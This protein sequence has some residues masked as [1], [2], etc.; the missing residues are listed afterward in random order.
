MT[1]AIVAPIG[2]ISM[3][4]TR[5]YQPPWYSG[6]LGIPERMGSNLDYGLSGDWASTRG[7]GSQVG[8]LSDR[9]SLLGGLLHPI[10]SHKKPP[11]LFRI[12]NK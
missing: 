2:M 10:N 4:R 12:K 7:N 5:K 8:G 1:W 9:L 11:T 6:G 3:L